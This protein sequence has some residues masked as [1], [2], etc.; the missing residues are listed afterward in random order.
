MEPETIEE[1][2]AQM[3]HS[4]AKRYFFVV[5]V[6]AVGVIFIAGLFCGRTLRRTLT[7]K[8]K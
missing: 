7:M 6:T 1:L 4:P 8:N 3:S 5:I 2:Y